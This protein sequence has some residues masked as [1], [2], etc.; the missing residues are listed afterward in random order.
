MVAVWNVTIRMLVKHCVVMTW[1]YKGGGKGG[2]LNKEYTSWAGHVYLYKDTNGYWWCN[3]VSRRDRN[4]LLVII[5]P[6]SPTHLNLYMNLYLRYLQKT[7]CAPSSQH[8]GYEWGRQRPSTFCNIIQIIY[9]T[10]TSVTINSG[11]QIQKIIVTFKI[12][13]QRKTI[14]V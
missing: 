8:C 12:L 1:E 3:R 10:Y 9:Q 4:C 5:P 13:P 6:P 14:S 11:T 7:F 2:F